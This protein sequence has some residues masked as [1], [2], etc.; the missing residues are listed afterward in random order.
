V[1]DYRNIG[2]LSCATCMRKTPT[3]AAGQHLLCGGGERKFQ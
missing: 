3:V 1:G 2:S